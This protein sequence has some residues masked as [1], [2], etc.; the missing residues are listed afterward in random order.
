MN[1]LDNTEKQRLELHT[2]GLVAFITY[3]KR[4][5]LI[6][7]LHT[8]VPSALGGRGV[9]KT[10]VEKSLSFIEAQ[11]WRLRPV[12]PFVNYFLRN[13]P[14]WQR[15][16]DKGYQ[17]KSLAAIEMVIPER[18][19]NIGMFDVGRVLPFRKKRMVGPFIYLD[20]MGPVNFAPGE[21]MDVPPHPHIG[22]A[23]LTYV[24]EGAI[25]HRDSTGA[26]QDILPGEV[27]V[28]TAGR[29]VSHSERSPD[30]L[31]SKGHSLFG[32]QFW[33]A[34]P[35]EKETTEPF[36]EHYD[37]SEL[38]EWEEYGVSCKLIAGKIGSRAT[39]VKVHSPLFLAVAESLQGGELILDD[40]FNGERAIY[41]VQ[42]E[43]NIYGEKYGK[44][45]LIVLNPTKAIA[46]QLS[47]GAKV[48][49]FGGEGFPEERHIWWNFVSTSQASIEEAKQRWSDQQF[50]QVPDETEFV[51]LPPK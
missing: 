49:I 12:C 41:V 10:M 37:T 35:K 45:N 27:N 40:D 5:S 33:I 11:G 17:P 6:Y 1:F 50:G 38:P 7:L 22:L 24:F 8:E 15:V 25:T 39:P 26:I 44:G 46:V 2:E 28:M 34:L 36:F 29:G 19:R 30:T 32:M 23:T 51:P 4:D 42:G 3:K 21:G 14:E 16:V 48:M 18:E 43:V 20:R 31:R 13:N 9:G 47:A